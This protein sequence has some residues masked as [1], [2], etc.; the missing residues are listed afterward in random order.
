[1]EFLAYSARNKGE[2]NTMKKLTFGL[3]ILL[4]VAF[5]GWS[6]ANAAERSLADILKEKGVITADEASEAKVAAPEAKLPKWVE[7][8]AFKGDLRL[9]YQGQ[10]REGSTSRHRYRM[11]FRVGATADITDTFSVGFRLA[12]GSDDPRSTNQ[13]FTDTFSTKQFNLDKAYVTWKPVKQFSLTGGKMGNPIWKTADL[14]WD[15]DITPEGVAAK[16]C[17]GPVFINAGW[18][19]LEELSKDSNDPMM[20]FAQVG[21]QMD[22]GPMDFAA[23]ATG[24]VF[25]D[26]KEAPLDHSAGTNTTNDEGARIYEYNSVAGDAE[27]GFSLSNGLRLAALGQVIYNFDPDNDEF[28]WLAGAKFGSKKIKKL[29]NWQVVY[30]YRYLEK[31]AWLDTFPDSDAFGGYTGVKG[32]EVILTTGLARNVT[33]AVDYYYMKEINNT[34]IDEHTVFVDFVFKF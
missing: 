17:F 32:H 28:G 24:Y 15:G 5:M 4:T 14:L 27:I 29:G 9:R 11:R 25:K 8:W 2:E 12:S 13:T 1:M 18:F 21:A 30:M 7:S 3:A 19:F 26:I 16:V 10:D 23:A 34:D 33:V 6:H 31:D 20:G 22:S